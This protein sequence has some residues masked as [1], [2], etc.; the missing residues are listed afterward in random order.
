MRRGALPTATLLGIMLMPCVARAQ[1]GAV[2]VFA[3]QLLVKN[4]VPDDESRNRVVVT[5]KDPSIGIPAPGSS[6]DPRCVGLPP[7]GYV[8]TAAIVVGP[9][10]QMDQ[11]PC[12][13]WTLLG[14]ETAPKGY[15]YKDR[16]LDDA[17]TQ[18]IVWKPGMLKMTLKGNGPSYLG[19][20][21]VPG[22]SIL[23]TEVTLFVYTGSY[24]YCVRCEPFNGKDGS[25]GKTFLGK[26]CAAPTVCFSSPSGAFLD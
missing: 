9:G 21:L 12:T 23:S 4:R 6:G 15:R 13:N 22:I 11:L 1:S 17:T 20:D 24:G 7:P 2:G 25:D 10:V 18:V 5:A 19:V 3:K 8:S 26:S 16:E 14:R